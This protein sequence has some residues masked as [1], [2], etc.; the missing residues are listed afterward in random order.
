V[1]LPELSL[2]G[3]SLTGALGDSTA[4]MWLNESGNVLF[5]PCQYQ[6][7]AERAVA[8]STGLFQSLSPSRVLLIGDM[9][10]VFCAKMST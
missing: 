2:A 9:K 7:K 4:L 10:V 1:L 3:N 5:I 6:V 8:W